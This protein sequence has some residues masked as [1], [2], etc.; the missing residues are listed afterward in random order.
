MEQVVE[1]L[2]KYDHYQIVL[3]GGG[4]K[5]KKAL[6]LWQNRYNN[7]LNVAGKF[8]FQEELSIIYG[9]KL[10]KGYEKVMDTIRPA[11][12]IAKIEEIVN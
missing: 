11:S 12:I 4:P 5:E 2:A 9:N 10:P 1:T 3:F 8:S 7:T 6:E